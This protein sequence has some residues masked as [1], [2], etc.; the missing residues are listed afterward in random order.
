MK[1]C[2]VKGN[3][4]TVCEACLGLNVCNGVR[5]FSTSFAASLAFLSLS[6]IS[7]QSIPVISMK[8][9]L[10]KNGKKIKA[11]YFKYKAFTASICQ[12]CIAR[13]VWAMETRVSN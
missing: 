5:I 3:Q 6:S 10:L 9:F 8:L 1:L 7:S 12:Q 11:N 4:E 2:T 13:V